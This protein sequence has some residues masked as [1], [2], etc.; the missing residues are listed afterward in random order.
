MGII[1]YTCVGMPIIGSLT[2]FFLRPGLKTTTLLTVTFLASVIFLAFLLWLSYSSSERHVE[3]SIAVDHTNRVI[4]GIENTMSLLKDTQTGQRGYLL[5]GKKEFLEPYEDAVVKIG[6]ALDSLARLT[7]DNRVQQRTLLIMRPVVERKIAQLAH[8]IYAYDTT[9]AV[10]AEWKKEMLAGK[11]IM[12]SVRMLANRMLAE[13][14]L[15]L[16]ARS[17]QETEARWTAARYM[18]LTTV[19]ALVLLAFY[20]VSVRH[21]LRQRLATQRELEL[22]VAALNQSNSE[23]EQFAYVASHDLQEPVRKMRAFSSRLILRHKPDLPPEAGHMLERINDS[24]HRMQNLIDDLLMFSRLV[25]S[26]S[27]PEL[28]DLSQI[29]AEVL[30]DLSES[31][32][33]AGASVHAASLPRCLVHHSQIKQLFQ[34]LIVNALKFNK[35]SVPLHIEITHRTVP[36]H[37]IAEARPEERENLFHQICVEDNG[38]GFDEQYLGKIFIIF[39]RLH[40]WEVYGGTGIGL[41]VCKRIVI[42]HGGYITARSQEGKGAVFVVYLPV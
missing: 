8:T 25:N 28:T 27:A 21:E 14:K 33:A 9:K 16:T 7:A 29:V 10:S 19:C 13:E 23:L 3:Y 4:V 30:D 26:H 34:N 1:F 39:Q 6:P 35:P 42:N 31:I 40:N 18:V 11:Q 38:I 17:G 2:H 41:A 32:T 36:G 24:A 15:L 12:D 5:T 22:K 37:D 20:F